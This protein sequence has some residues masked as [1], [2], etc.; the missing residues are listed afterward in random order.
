MSNGVVLFNG[1]SMG[2]GGSD[3]LNGLIGD[4]L[5][6]DEVSA[7]YDKE[8]MQKLGLTYTVPLS[9][10]E[11]F[12]SM[13]GAAELDEVEESED[14]PIVDLS[15]APGKGFKIKLFGGQYK[16]SK[17]FVEWV[18]K[19]KTLE[20]ADSSV[21]KEWARIARRIKQLDKSKVKTKSM[22]F[23]KLFTLGFSN[24]ALN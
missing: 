14:L 15:K 3:L 2:A 13:V 16:V 8:V 21:K 18:K 22:L 5:D 24:T 4:L 12:D 7:N 10:D 17:L 1:T 11:T 19:A 23:A 20:E 6:Q 9:P